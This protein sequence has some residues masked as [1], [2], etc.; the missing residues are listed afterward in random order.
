MADKKEDAERRSWSQ[1]SR[2][3]DTPA[4]LSM[5]SQQVALV[6][7]TG[8]NQ[9]HTLAVEKCLYIDLFFIF[10]NNHLNLCIKILKK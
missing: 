1:T 6:R 3:T 4:E 2:A 7:R 8:S 9:T 10:I 5:P